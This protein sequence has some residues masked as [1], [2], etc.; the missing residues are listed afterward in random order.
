MSLI[1]VTDETPA[2]INT[3]LRG[4]GVVVCVIMLLSMLMGYGVYHQARSTLH[5]EF[6]DHVTNIT[7]TAA[8]LTDADAHDKA[9]ENNGRNVEQLHAP[10][11]RML[12]ASPDVNALYT[13]IQT[14][15][16]KSY[17]YVLY[18]ELVKAGEVKP[19][20]HAF[21]P[22][23]YTTP[24]LEEA[25]QKKHTTIDTQKLG[26][27]VSGYTPF[28]DS[29][30]TFVGLVAADIAT[31]DFLTRQDDLKHRLMMCLLIS[32]AIALVCGACFW[33]YRQTMTCTMHCTRQNTHDD[34]QKEEEISA[35]YE[36]QKLVIEQERRNKGYQLTSQLQHT[37]D[38]AVQHISD[39]ITQLQQD[40]QQANT[41]ATHTRQNAAIMMDA[42]QQSTESTAYISTAAEQ[43]TLSIREISKQTVRSSLVAKQANS[44]AQEA[45]QRIENLSTQ[46]A[47]VENVITIIMRIAR[48]I[49]M[50][51]MNATIEAARA[52]E[53]G[54][55][56]AVVANEVKT[57]A[58][59][60]ASATDQI[61]TQIQHMREAT[62]V[63]VDSV[64]KIMDIIHDVAQSTDAVAAAV[65]EQSAVT[66]DIA[67][68]IIRSSVQSQ[69]M[70]ESIGEV[71]RYADQSNHT[72][73]HVLHSANMLGQ[74]MDSLRH[75]LE[76][77]IRTLM[78]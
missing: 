29:T 62:H 11:R 54:R 35:I 7:L 70:S 12:Q 22:Y 1:R 27:V 31:D 67:Q 34:T 77:H 28:Y 21:T 75:K 38:G 49:N 8:N 61:T 50:L 39:A 30:G 15:E 16:A 26:T 64:Q 3:A 2:P 65:E 5:Q 76:A 10:Y 43:L 69:R 68:N 53:S 72:A 56:F 74:Q 36:R 19:T 32:F 57:L 59:Q 25:F 52:G 66:N 63:S 71:Q 73:E 51:A 60:V 13:I 17:A 40:A 20:P 46:S 23:P 4:A 47:K 24:A 6:Y 48:Q 41:I 9:S 14:G 44:Q 33:R 55:G 42:S 78:E 58:T 37:I 18:E 45:K